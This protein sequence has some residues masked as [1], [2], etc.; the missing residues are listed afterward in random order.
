MPQFL[1][2]LLLTFGTENANLNAHQN[3]LTWLHG[4]W[5]HVAVSSNATT[6]I[7]STPPKCPKGKHVLFFS[8]DG[9]LRKYSPRKGWNRLLLDV[10]VD[11]E[12][13]ILR[14]RNRHRN[15]DRFSLVAKKTD[16]GLLKM[17]MPG[18]GDFYYKKLDPKTRLK[19]ID[20]IRPPTKKPSQAVDA[21]E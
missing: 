9:E 6:G 20:F 1:F 19:E 8:P 5:L 2:A 18:Y 3:E 4:R 13:V 11:E 14:H 12:T 10:S 16:E 15:R 7:A 21:G 17:C